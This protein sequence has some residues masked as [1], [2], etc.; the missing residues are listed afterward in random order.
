MNRWILRSLLMALGAALLIP[1]ARAGDDKDTG[2]VC[3]NRTIK[4]SYAFRVSGE[5]FASP[6][7]P[8]AITLYR[9]GVAMAYFDGATNS[10][11]KGKLWQEDYILGNGAF[12]PP[13]TAF[14]NTDTN[15][16]NN[17]ETGTYQVFPDCTGQGEIDFPYTVNTTPA[18]IPH[19]IKL[20]FVI[21]K[22]GEI[23]HAIVSSLEVLT[24]ANTVSTMSVNIHSDAERVGDDR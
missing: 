9:D 15:E 7:P 21:A 22:H 13:D 2:F 12:A 1:A 8:A 5:V 18:P 17:G 16:F 3:S 24:P 4:G 6:A 14:Q 23:M 10:A 11:G 19:V 20:K